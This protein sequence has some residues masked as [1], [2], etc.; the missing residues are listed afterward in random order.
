MKSYQQWNEDFAPAAPNDVAPMPNIGP[1]NRLGSQVRVA[2]NRFDKIA[3]D[4]LQN[5]NNNQKLHYLVD[6]IMDLVGSNPEEVHKDHTMLSKLRSLIIKIDS[7][8]KQR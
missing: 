4:S 1:Q 5:M 6:A 3:G 8:L 7:A 2:S